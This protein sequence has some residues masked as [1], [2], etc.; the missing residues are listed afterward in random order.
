MPVDPGLGEVLARRV[1]QLYEAAEV[2]LLRR[3]SAALA[4]GIDSPSWAVEKLARLDVLR[5]SMRTEVDD[6]TRAADAEVWSVIRDAWG[7]GRRS[8]LEDLERLERTPP[9]TP[10]S[11]EAGLSRIAE[12]TLG[13]IRP[14]GP[15]LLRGAVDL[16]QRVAAQA[17]ATVL[18]GGD[19]RLGAA[20]DALD[21]LTRRGVRTFVDRSGRTWEGASYVEMAVRTGSGHA[22][23]QG[24]VDQ[25]QTAGIDLV[26]VTDHPR[27]CPL[28][29]PWEGKV[30]SLGS[31]PTGR[32][33]LPSVRGSGTV[34][35]DVA[36]TLDRARSAGFQHP[37]CRHAVSAYLPGASR[38][39]TKT[40]DTDERYAEGQYQRYLE[41]G[42][43]E[44]KRR[45][46]VAITP[47][48]QRYT[49]AKV[50]EWQSRLRQHLDETEGLTRS[51]SREQ[52]GTRS[53][54]R[55]R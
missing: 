52:I 1:S 4:S 28:C 43:R 44:W 49:R 24:H 39:A 11:V 30:L 27:E 41:R 20:Q 21:S 50:R 47:D 23:V 46:S 25:L 36:G 16:Y 38:P 32:L 51:P 31:G 14:V 2:S 45:E 13:I 40:K 35:V 3:V 54:P 5:R 53:R 9:R 7:A 19:T 12:E 17:S 34:V 8:A 26:F 15:A 29:R 42:I 10:P 18:L 55:A 33:E 48:A 6:L 22:A 37:N